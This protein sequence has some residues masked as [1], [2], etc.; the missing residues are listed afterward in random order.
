MPFRLRWA[1]L[2]KP[3]VDVY[4]RQVISNVVTFTIVD[5]EKEAE[6]IAAEK[7]EAERIAAEKAEA[8]RIAAEKAEAERV[9]A[10]QAAAQSA[11]SQQSSQ[12][13]NS[14]TVYVTP[15]GKKYHYNSNC[16]G[17]SYSPTTLEK[18]LAMNLTPCKKC[19]G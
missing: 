9:A 16:N 2:Q 3:T 7:A 4:K 10:E 17:G 11:A 12:Q 14:R 13:T 18:A 19:V 8:E 5:A 6:R 1:V 15:T